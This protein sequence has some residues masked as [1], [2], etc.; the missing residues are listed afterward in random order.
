MKAIA[1]FMGV[2]DNNTL[3][4]D[5]LV[6]ITPMIMDSKNKHIRIILVTA[7]IPFIPGMYNANLYNE[8][9]KC[10]VRSRR[11][12]MV[13]HANIPFFTIGSVR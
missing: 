12:A 2:L 6:I 3:L 4:S 9:P 13:S 8:E 5:I 11:K 7:L 1:V 10:N